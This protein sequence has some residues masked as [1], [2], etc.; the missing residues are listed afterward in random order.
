M[1]ALQ[2]ATLAAVAASA[3]PAPSLSVGA[4]RQALAHMIK[5][6]QAPLAFETVSVRSILCA[7]V[8]VTAYRVVL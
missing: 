4:D 1:R 8:K 3:T 7:F 2:T 5:N 6:N